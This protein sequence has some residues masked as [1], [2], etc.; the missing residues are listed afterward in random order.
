MAS[1]AKTYEGSC[2]CGAVRYQVD[3]ALGP[4]V[5]CNCSICTRAGTLLVFVPADAFQVLSG[6]DALGDYQFGQKVIH[7]HFCQICGIRPFSRGKD[8]EG[9]D[10]VAVNVRCLDGVDID[11]LQIVRFDGRSL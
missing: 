11:A 9:R 4:V 2:H 8:R 7:H 6:S 3:L 1:E 5:S 10:V